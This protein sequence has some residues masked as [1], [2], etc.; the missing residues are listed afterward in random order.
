MFTVNKYEATNIGQFGVKAGA[1]KETSVTNFNKNWQ[2][3]KYNINGS[4]RDTY[5]YNDNGGNAAMH[6]P[7]S[8]NRPTQF[9]PNVNRSPDV[10]AGKKFAAVN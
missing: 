5:I 2:G 4:G 1:P 6:G 3:L 10:Q 9:L 7:R 8:Q